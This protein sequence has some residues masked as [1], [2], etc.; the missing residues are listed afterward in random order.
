MNDAD[1]RTCTLI[2]GGICHNSFILNYFHGFQVL[3]EVNSYEMKQGKEKTKLRHIPFLMF[4][5]IHHDG[6]NIVISNRT[7]RRK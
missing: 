4:I 2:R 5:R 7:L 3:D 1:T 6:V